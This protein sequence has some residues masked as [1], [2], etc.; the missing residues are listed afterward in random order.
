MK[1]CERKPF[2]RQVMLTI[3]I[4]AWYDDTLKEQNICNCRAPLFSWEES[5]STCSS[6]PYTTSPP[7]AGTMEMCESSELVSGKIYILEIIVWAGIQVLCEDN[8]NLRLYYDTTMGAQK[9]M[10]HGTVD[11]VQIVSSSLTIVVCNLGW[12]DLE[13]ECSTD[14]PWYLVAPVVAHQLGKPTNP[15]PG[16]RPSVHAAS[17]CMNLNL[18][19][20]G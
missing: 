19:T 5:L 8:L 16:F 15:H 12:V 2:G 1:G 3:S 20:G 4:D 13:I 18:S 9:S 17:P 10:R 14:P 7:Q 11:Y 6:R